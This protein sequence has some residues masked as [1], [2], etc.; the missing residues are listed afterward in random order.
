MF[1]QT[2]AA[3]GG[4]TMRFFPGR[5]VLEQ[6]SAQFDEPGQAHG[7]PLAAAL[8][9]IEG[10]EAVAFD[11]DFIAV[12][13]AGNADWQVLKPPI[14]GLIMEHFIAGRPIMEVPNVHEGMALSGADAETVRAIA[15]VIEDRIDP[16]LAAE[17]GKLTLQG[18]EAGVARVS[19]EGP[20]FSQP[21]F[22]V[23]VK[24]ENTLKNYA[25]GVTEVEFVHEP[26]KDEAGWATGDD[27]AGLMTPEA[28]AIQE[29]LQDRINPAVASHGGY[30][31][32]VD[33]RDHRA[34][35]RLEGG[36]QGCGMSSATL[37]QGV[38]VE[39]MRAVPTISQVVDVT[40]HDAGANPYY[41]PGHG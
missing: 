37:S 10:V 21:L 20:R 19:L 30:I 29:I 31:S 14:L 3:A 17:G 26:A 15:A 8:F 34:Y 1:I 24:I 38:E 11:A 27:G 35:I 23:K 6:G 40:D 39:I 36:C 33:V 9:K 12:G 22:A 13:K 2:E 18:F 32:L 28:Q 5:A 16:G 41:Q 7:S 4:S 25:P